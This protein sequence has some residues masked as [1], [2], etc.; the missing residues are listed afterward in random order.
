[1]TSEITTGDSRLGTTKA[2]TQ[3]YSA[4]TVRSKTGILRFFNTKKR[5]FTFLN[6]LPKESLAAF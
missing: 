3:V 5:D 1:M 6:D 2:L 4:Y